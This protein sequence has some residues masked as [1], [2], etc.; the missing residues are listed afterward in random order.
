[1]SVWIISAKNQKIKIITV[2]VT[3]LLINT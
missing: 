1:V 2:D 3:N